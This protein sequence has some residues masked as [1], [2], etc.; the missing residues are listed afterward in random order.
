MTPE[1]LAAIRERANNATP[2]PWEYVDDYIGVRQ[3][4]TEAHRTGRTEY[5][6]EG[7][8]PGEHVRASDAVFI[9]AAR[10]DIPA[11]LDHIKE[12]A[13]VIQALNA[14][15]NNALSGKVHAHAK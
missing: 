3:V 13:S 4:P 14:G 6:V 15:D 8:I 9:A 12:Q 2:G 10:D 7:I 1:Q 5:E 11:L